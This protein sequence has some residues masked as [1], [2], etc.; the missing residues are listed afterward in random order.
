MSKV[1]SVYVQQSSLEQMK[2]VIRMRLARVSPEVPTEVVVVD[3][4]DGWFRVEGWVL[5][6][7]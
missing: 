6:A 1:L 4:G 2:E 3:Q 5:G 7:D